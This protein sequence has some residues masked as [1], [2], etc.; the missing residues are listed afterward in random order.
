MISKKMLKAMNYQINRE[1]Y[2]AYLYMGMASYFKSVNLTGFANWMEVQVKEE[3]FHANKF[4]LF[5]AERGGRVVFDTIE[6][7]PQEWSSSLEVFEKVLEHEQH[8]TSLINDLVALS[9]EQKDYATH[10]FLQWFVNEQVEEEANADQIIQNLKLIGEQGQGIFMIDRE[11]ALRVFTP[12]V[13]PV[14]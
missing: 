10:H 14:A 3:L 6:S 12:P 5:V 7:P 2:S 8:V 4:Y 11:L 9:I 13:T 1:M